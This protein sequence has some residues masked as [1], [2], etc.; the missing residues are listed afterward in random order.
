MCFVSLAVFVFAD[1]AF[2]ANAPRWEFTFPYGN[3]S[4]LTSVAVSADGN[5]YLA[6]SVIG[7]PITAT[8]GA[9][10][11]QNNGGSAACL[12]GSS[13]IAV[14]QPAPCANA[15]VIKLD[16]GGNVIFATYF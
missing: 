5:T 11:P 6:G 10:Q 8:P 9:Y 13:G 7:N 1:L 2:A 16:P 12:T 3:G 15:F 14:P 4:A